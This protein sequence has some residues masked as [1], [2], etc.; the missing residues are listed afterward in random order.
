MKGVSL[1]SSSCPWSINWRRWHI[2]KSASSLATIHVIWGFKV[3]EIGVWFVR[4]QFSV[5]YGLKKPPHQSCPPTVIHSCISLTT[6]LERAKEF[7]CLT[8]SQVREPPRLKRNGQKAGMSREAAPSSHECCSRGEW[9]NMG[10]RIAPSERV[11]ACATMT[12]PWTHHPDC[13]KGFLRNNSKFKLLVFNYCI[14]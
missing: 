9:A 7:W 10:D 12:E 14:E 3:Q 6:F 1:I 2:C 11:S 8:A 5:Q 4:L 13:W